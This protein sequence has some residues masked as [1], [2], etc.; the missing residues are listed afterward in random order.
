VSPVRSRGYANEVELRFDEAPH[1]GSPR[2][3]CHDSQLREFTHRLGGERTLAIG[4]LQQDVEFERKLYTSKVL[5][6]RVE[7]NDVK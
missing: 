6:G 3:T 7:S 2:S 4:T 5:T 1:L